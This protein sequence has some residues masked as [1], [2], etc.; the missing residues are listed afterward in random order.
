MADGDILGTVITRGDVASGATDSGSPVKVAG[1]YNSTLP[2]LTDGQRGE[3]QVGTRGSL[4]IQVKASDSTSNIAGVM[5]SEGIAA[6]TQGLFT[7]AMGYLYNGST[8]DHRRSSVEATLL[9]SSA[10]T[11]TQTS[12]DI[13]TYGLK[14]IHVILDVTTPGTGSITVTIN[15]KDPASGKYYLLLS[16][17]AVT[18][19]VTNVYKVGPALTAAAN[20]A[21]NDYLPRTIQIVVTANN[22][23]SMT[24][25]VG[26]T[27]MAG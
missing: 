20:A 22:A 1:K 24:Y 27:L 8:F 10:R 7:A 6:A 11:T 13:V 16:G 12:A 3:L 23:N 19:A 2:T 4:N 17:A 21:A 18:T 15:G 14:A 26:Y 5:S 25:S 9:T